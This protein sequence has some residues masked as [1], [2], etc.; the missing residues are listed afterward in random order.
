MLAQTQIHS[1]NKFWLEITK[2]HEKIQLLEQ[3]LNKQYENKTL[4]F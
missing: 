1:V 2:K 3:T 4:T